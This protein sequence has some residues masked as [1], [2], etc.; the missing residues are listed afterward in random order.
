MAK[1]QIV[2]IV[3]ADIECEESKVAV[4]QFLLLLKDS[5]PSART[6]TL[7]H[8]QQL[9]PVIP[10][11]VSPLALRFDVLLWRI[12]RHTH[13]AFSGISCFG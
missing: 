1:A 5:T 4:L 10:K 3:T 7:G 2:H 8:C 9:L 13:P 6:E 11:R 12:A